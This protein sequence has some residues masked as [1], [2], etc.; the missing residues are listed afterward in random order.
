MKYPVRQIFLWMGLLL[1]GNFLQ[2]AEPTLTQ[3]TEAMERAINYFRTEVGI[4]GGYLWRYAAD[5][6]EREGEVPASPTTAWVQPPGTPAVGM[7]YLTAYELTGNPVCLE[8]AQETGRALV[9]G[10]LESGGWDY[11]IEFKAEDRLKHAY[12]VD[13]EKSSPGKKR[14]TTTLDDNTSQ[15]ALRFLMRVDRALKFEDEKIHAAALYALDKL[16]EAQYPN[17]AWPQRFS[18]P[19]DP[20]KFPVKRAEYPESWPPAYPKQDYR[21]YY[22]FNDNTMADMIE[23]MFL[24]SEI[25]QEERY[26]TAG[27]RG[28][29][30][31][32]LAQMPE[33]QPGWAQ[34]YNAQ[35]HPAWARKFEP[36]GVTG[37]ESQG[38][39][40]TLLRLYELTGDRKYL[41]P[42]PAALAYFRR[43]VLENGQLARFYELKTNKP[44]YFTK[45]YEVTY[46]DSDLPTH[47]GFKASNKLDA[48]EAKYKRLVTRQ[49]SQIELLRLLKK[50]RVP[51]LSRS[52]TSKATQTIMRLDQRGAWVEPAPK[53]SRSNISAGT[54]SL[55][56]RTFSDNLITLA[57]YVAALKSIESP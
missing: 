40:R 35:M 56:S 48:I 57:Q 47:Y 9:Q 50:P 28:G 14:N 19:C 4:E 10:Q 1:V 16:I 29:E 15:A 37:G 53:R 31:I 20:D 23:T 6:S 24:A 36:P 22:T 41:E 3:A 30:F 49:D 13:S 7:A 8:A 45:K 52:L 34:Q 12:R 43:S 33:P 11:R 17:G 5:F 25:Y 51:E 42:L 39:M 21:S 38:V 2:A 55:S 27:K 54:P 32:L 18:G 26:S 46:D 44:L